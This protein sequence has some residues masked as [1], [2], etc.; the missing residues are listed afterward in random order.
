LQ[1]HGSSTILILLFSVIGRFFP[2]TIPHL[3][4]ENFAKLYL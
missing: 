2:V 3:M 1:I 4:H